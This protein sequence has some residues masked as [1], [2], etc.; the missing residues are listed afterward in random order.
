M[1][2]ES[3]VQVHCEVDCGAESLPSHF[4][5]KREDQRYEEKTRDILHEPNIESLEK[6]W[7]ND[8]R[9]GAG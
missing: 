6:W 3:L 4:E 7:R 1:P 9:A 2:Q 8:V 5:F